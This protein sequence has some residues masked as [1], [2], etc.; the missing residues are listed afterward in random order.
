MT[1]IPVKSDVGALFMNPA[2]QSVQDKNSGPKEN[3]SDV[4]QKQSGSVSGRE[5]V[6]SDVSGR[7][8][9]VDNQ[10]ARIKEQQEQK[11]VANTDETEGQDGT[12]DTEEALKAAEE[13]AGQLMAQMAQE[14]GISVEQVMEL[15]DQ[16]GLKPMDL[17]NADILADVLLKAASEENPLSLVTNETLYGTFQNLNQTLQE[18]ME[19]IA[20][21][22]GMEPA[23]V[24]QLVTQALTDVKGG[25]ETLKEQ[26]IGP[27][28][29]EE[30]PDDIQEPE[31]NQSRTVQDQNTSVGKETA[32]D[33][34][35]ITVERQQ[36]RNEHRNTENGSQGKDNNPN[37]FAQNLTAKTEFVQ[38]AANVPAPEIFHADTEKIM[39]QIM[40]YMK[41]QLGAEST[42][43]EMQLHPE[44]LG[45][46]HIHI[47]S[48]EGALTAQF[49]TQNEAV[50]T[51]L[52]SQMIQ[53]KESFQEQG[54]KVEAIEVMVES[55]AFERNLEQGRGRGQEENNQPRQARVRKIDLDGLQ[56][57]EEG[58]LSSDDRITAEMMLQNGNTVDYTA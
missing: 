35:E 27:V 46:L 53:L 45:T 13:L 2:P 3:F 11:E 17:L 52:E 15:L 4:L 8:V 1:S 5:A 50:K 26:M 21:M 55:H 10:A 56:G 29:S 23:D 38:N 37:P 22:T 16:A 41:I 47:A 9:K 6:K 44:S 20:Q 33:A 24:E 58:E 18:G 7:Q 30:R 12:K 14:L 42:S 57:L 36:N 31:E 28:V 40:D 48:K 54:V 25:A 32:G 19:Q 49:T 34:P 39:K 51:A 43:L